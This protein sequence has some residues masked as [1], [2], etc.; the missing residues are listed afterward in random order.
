MIVSSMSLYAVGATLDIVTEI[1]NH[2][3]GKPVEKNNG[4]GTVASDYL[5]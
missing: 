4:S 5:G 2:M 3:M 1:R